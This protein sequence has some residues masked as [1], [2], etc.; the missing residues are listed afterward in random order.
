[1]DTFSWIPLTSI[2]PE[3]IKYAR[4]QLHQSIQNVSAV[5]RKFLDQSA[6]DVNATLTWVPG[7]RRMAGKWVKGDISFRSSISL[8]EFTIYLVDEK[9]QTLSSFNCNDK[10]QTQLM[11]WLEEQ[12][13]KFGLEAKNL[14]LN[15]PYE[16]PK[17]VL[18]VGNPF[19]LESLRGAKELTKYFHNAY[20]TIREFREQFS[21]AGEINIWPHHFDMAMNVLLRDTGDPETNT[22]ISL[23]MSPGDD[24]FESPYFYV[25]C[26]PH[27][28]T[29]NLP[30]LSNNAMW[31]SEEWTGAVL[32][33]KHLQNAKNQEDI[34]RTFLAE[35]STI[36]MNDLT[37]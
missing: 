21:A 8:E 31:I 36:L 10:T 1:M 25:N 16:L 29:R 11:L 33:S 20:I 23:G 2:D 26:W 15:L 5:G 18:E 35:A 13:G 24:Q 12:I 22:Q 28:D 27:V 17:E 32:L 9:V 34:T 19:D 3:E 4:I 7:H 30:Q 6:G 14:T 37:K